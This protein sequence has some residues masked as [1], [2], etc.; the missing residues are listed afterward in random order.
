MSNLFAH[1]ILKFLVALGRIISVWFGNLINFTFYLYS[2]WCKNNIC[3]VIR[4]N[5]AY[6]WIIVCR[7]KNFGWFKYFRT[8]MKYPGSVFSFHKFSPILICIIVYYYILNRLRRS[9]HLTWLW[10][11]RCLTCSHSIKVIEAKTECWVKVP[12]MWNL[13]VI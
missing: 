2:H 6:K 13:D 5:C 3:L 4:S 1:Q 7:T 8:T 10:L 11:Y 9:S 12:D